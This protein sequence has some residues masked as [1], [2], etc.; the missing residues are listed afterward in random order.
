MDEGEGAVEE[1]DGEL[2]GAAEYRRPGSQPRMYHGSRGMGNY[3]GPAQLPSYDPYRRLRVDV[4]KASSRPKASIG[5]DPSED[6]DAN[7]GIPDGSGTEPAGAS[8]EIRRQRLKRRRHSVAPASIKCPTVS[9]LGCLL[10]AGRLQHAAVNFI[11]Q[12][13]AFARK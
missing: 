6:T 12:G 11:H 2:A 3:P 1:G 5:T 13:S 8:S 7:S 10:W 9:I 4:I